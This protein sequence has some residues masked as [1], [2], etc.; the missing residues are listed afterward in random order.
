MSDP[1]RYLGLL[2]KTRIEA[3][4]LFPL[5]HV[6]KNVLSVSLGCFPKYFHSKILQVMVA[7]HIGREVGMEFQITE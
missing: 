7:M 3:E 6:T 2:S 4:T 1:L 5:P